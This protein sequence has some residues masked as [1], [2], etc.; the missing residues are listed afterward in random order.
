MA[1]LQGGLLL[2]QTTRATRHLQLSL[3]MALHHIA[4]HLRDPHHAIPTAAASGSRPRSA[5]AP[6]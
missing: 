3:N 2:T 5:A 1:A 6:G 4:R